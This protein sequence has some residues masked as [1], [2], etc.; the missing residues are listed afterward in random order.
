MPKK[1]NLIF[2]RLPIID[3]VSYQSQ[4][5]D[6]KD[7]QPS[8]DWCFCSLCW[9]CKLWFWCFWSLL[10]FDRS[11]GKGCLFTVCRDK[12]ERDIDIILS[13]TININ[14]DTLPHANL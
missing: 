9:R 5:N 4:N 2:L 8:D 13:I 3:I 12:N 14:T 7:N 10:C 6:S 1:K 11:K